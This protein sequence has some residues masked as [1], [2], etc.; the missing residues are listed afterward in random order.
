M[1]KKTLN[2]ANL[3]GLGAERLA[4][5][6]IE[7]STGSADIKRRL[8]LELSHD[9]GPLELA[10]DLRK[11]LV[12]LRKARSFV[13]WRKRKALIKDLQTQA[14]MIIE[15]IAP[16]APTEAFDLLWQFLELAGPT[17]ERVDDSR[18]EVGDVF[19][20][21]RS[22]LAEIAPRAMLA[23]I[24]LAERVWE[25][26]RDD[27]YGAFDGVIDLTAEA[28]GREGLTHLE[29]LVKAYE[30][31]PIETDPDHPALQFLRELR[32][33]SASYLADAKARMVKHTLQEIADAAGDTEAYIAQFSDADLSR[34]RTAADIAT[35][36][37][38]NGDAELAMSYLQLA[39]DARSDAA[40]DDAYIA[41]LLALGQHDAAQAHRWQCFETRLSARHLRDHLKELD[42]FEDVEAEDRAKLHVLA[43]PDVSAALGFLLDWPDLHHAARLVE[44]RSAELNGDFYHILTPAA[45]ALRNRH[46]LAAVLLWRAMIDFALTEGRSSRYGHAAD[47][48]MDCAALDGEIDDYGTAESHDDYVVRL[49]DRHQRKTSFWAR[50]G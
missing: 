3:A 33:G 11:R 8:R 27:G 26:L 45:D 28:L 5:L 35:R 48:L 12:S 24:Q 14:D 15:R 17:S 16:Q 44:A 38:E 39:E 30:A 42:D 29:A 18:G 43:Y 20:G 50:L 2:A 41:C 22:H 31:A 34:P 32:G 23:P 13:T 4:E 36:L 49:Q 6:L 40:W 10:R 37:L 1:S 46:P 9:L 47:H 25:A 21:A 7:V 19:R